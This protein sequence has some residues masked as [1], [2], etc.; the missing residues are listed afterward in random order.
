MFLGPWFLGKIVFLT[1]QRKRSLQ[2]YSHVN[3]NKV[4]MNRNIFEVQKTFP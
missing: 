4:S 1:V 2:H 3:C